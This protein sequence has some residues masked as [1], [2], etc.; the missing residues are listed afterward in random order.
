[1]V[2][3]LLVIGAVVLAAFL[4]WWF[5]EQER[6][7]LAAIAA[8]CRKGDWDYDER[9]RKSPTHPYEL[10]SRGHSR[11][12]RCTATGSF[13]GATPGLAQAELTLFEY[14]YAVA[15]GKHTEHHYY[16]CLV[17]DPGAD[18]GHVSLRREGLGDKLIQ[19]AGFDDI[20][21]EDPDFSK[22]FVVQARDRRDAY[23]LFDGAMMR[24][25]CARPNYGLETRG[26]ELFVYWEG[27]ASPQS[28][29]ALARFALGF[30]AQLPRPLVN[31]ERAR[32]GLEPELEAGNAST[33]S[34][35]ALDRLTDRRP[36]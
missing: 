8:W 11:Y 4:G 13:E 6:K 34:R 30:L 5:Y 28:F 10:F 3:I 27:Q 26:R 20:D 14:H 21:F 7:R 15:R 23:E 36:T 2:Q 31:A 9:E 33:S 25:L 22:R 18:L 12:Q 1:L 16:T 29:Q 17:A 24:Y 19:A 35:Q 32:Q